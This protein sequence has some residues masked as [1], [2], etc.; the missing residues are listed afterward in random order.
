M[1]SHLGISPVFKT[2]ANSLVF[3]LKRLR[4]ITKKLPL[5]VSFFLCSIFTGLVGVGDC[6]VFDSSTDLEPQASSFLS[7]MSWASFTLITTKR[8]IITEKSL[9]GFPSN[10]ED[11]ESAFS[12]S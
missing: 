2:G 4:D 8:E 7:S 3:K 1:F 11:I 10:F 6:V 12:S 9:S 5:G